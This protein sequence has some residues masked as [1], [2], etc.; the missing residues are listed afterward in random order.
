M[1]NGVAGRLCQLS[2]MMKS[3]ESETSSEPGAQT[4]TNL[5]LGS[6]E[7]RALREIFRALWVFAGYLVV[8]EICGGIFHWGRLTNALLQFVPYCFLMAAVA[9][10][11]RRLVRVHRPTL[12]MGACLACVFLVF[13]FDLTKNLSWFN[14]VPILGRDSDVRNDIASVAMIVALATFPAASYYMMQEIL[15]AKQELDEKV[16]ELRDALGH[17]W[18]LQGLLP[19]C[20]WCHKIRTDQ[21]SWQRIDLY[22]SE[23]S[24]TRFTHGVCPD[25]ARE[26]YPGLQSQKE[27]DMSGAKSV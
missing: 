10:G 27:G 18:R 15:V 12:L 2:A 16:A 3:T 25:C 11:G 24:D 5:R 7:R 13:S 21:E 26:R 4:G 9:H 1:I 17:V 6:A 22:I 20:M 23:H 14:G 8:V 19:I